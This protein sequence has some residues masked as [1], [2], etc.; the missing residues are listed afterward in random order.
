MKTTITSLLG[1]LLLAYSSFCLADMELIA[2]DGKRILL[3]DD[4]SWE[5]VEKDKSNDSSSR[6]AYLSV[7]R[8]ED[9]AGSC[10]IGLRLRNGLAVKIGSLVL[11][12][13]AYTE[14][15]IVYESVKR[16]F[17]NIKP[18]KHLYKEITFRGLKCKK[19][20]TL[21]VH[22]G[23]HCSSGDLTKYSTKD[24]EC[25]ERVYVEASDKISIYKRY[26]D[27]VEPEIEETTD[28]NEVE[29]DALPEERVQDVEHLNP[30][31]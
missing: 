13:S 23:D 31:P 1:S 9:T 10:R 11:S 24:G 25:L 12:F 3:K 18:T 6:Y 20:K 5:Y 2:P 14:E 28:E 22:G 19:I 16:G 8:V 27:E 29:Q 17:P 26:R 21:R 15:D 7:V 4:M 30:T